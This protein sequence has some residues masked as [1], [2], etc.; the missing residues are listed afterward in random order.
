M[1]EKRSIRI[2]RLV[3]LLLFLCVFLCGLAALYFF[4]PKAW[5]VLGTLFAPDRAAQ[6][7]V[8]VDGKAT[9]VP[10]FWKRHGHLDDR[11][12]EVP[13][14]VVCGIPCGTGRENLKIFPDGLGVFQDAKDWFCYSPRYLYLRSCA[15]LTMPLEDDMKGWD[16][17]YRI[18][19]KDGGVHYEIFPAGPRRPERIVFSIPKKMLSSV[20]PLGAA[21]RYLARDG[22]V[23]RC[24]PYRVDEPKKRLE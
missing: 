5:T 3:L 23:L 10:V 15:L 16:T 17:E 9:T 14:L 20:P 2:L 6:V 13:V 22:E 1:P 18:A 7:R 11:G 12:K 19:E 24:L 4:C 21:G 8:S